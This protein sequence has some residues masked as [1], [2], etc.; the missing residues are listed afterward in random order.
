M[1]F[2]EPVNFSTCVYVYMQIFNVRDGHVTTFRHPS[3][4]ISA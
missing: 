1:V 3:G 4:P 2:L